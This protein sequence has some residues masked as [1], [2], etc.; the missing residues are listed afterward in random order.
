MRCLDARVGAAPRGDDEP[1]EGEPPAVLDRRTPADLIQAL[2]GDLSRASVLRVVDREWL[3]NEEIGK[4]V[5]V[6]V[7]AFRARGGLVEFG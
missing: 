4:H 1:W 6:L 3:A 2:E 5:D 7:S